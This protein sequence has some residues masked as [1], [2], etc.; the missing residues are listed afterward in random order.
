MFLMETQNEIRI[1]S[2]FPAEL[3]DLIIGFVKDGKTFKGLMETC[4]Y[5]HKCHKHNY[6]K[7]CNQLWTLIERYPEKP[8]DWKYISFNPNITMEIIEKNPGKPWNWYRISKNPNI[9]M[10]IIEKYPEREWNWEYISSNPNI[11]IE[12]IE[13]YSDK[14]WNWYYISE[15]PNITMEFIE[16]YSD[17]SWNWYYISKNPFRKIKNH[18]LYK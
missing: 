7:Y 17:K 5:F 4:K 1:S 16:K 9:T 6:L 2:F 3:F 15:N 14:S 10:G 13:K 18:N 8:W 12:I 11:T